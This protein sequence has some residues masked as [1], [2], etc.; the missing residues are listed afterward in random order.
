MINGNQEAEKGEILRQL[1]EIDEM[2]NDELL[3]KYEA[4]HLKDQIDPDGMGRQLY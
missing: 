1:A 3:D 2:M 4:A